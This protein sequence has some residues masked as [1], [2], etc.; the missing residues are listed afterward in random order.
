ML[1]STVIDNFLDQEDFDRLEIT[2]SDKTFPWFFQKSLNINHASLENDCKYYFCHVFYQQEFS[3]QFFNLVVPLWRKLDIKACLRIKANCYPSTQQLVE[4]DAHVD[5]DFE[6][7]GAIL[8]IN[9]NDGYTRLNNGDIIESVRN[10][11][12]IFEPNILHSS[13]NCTDKK[14][15]FNININYF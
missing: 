2:V 6:H 12:L 1:K 14:A 15:R 10:R 13:T 5:Y 4:H 7:K 11:L 8:Y 3:S 9:N